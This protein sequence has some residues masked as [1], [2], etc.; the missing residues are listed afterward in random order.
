[1][2]NKNRK[3]IEAVLEADDL[4]FK[5]LKRVSDCLIDPSLEVN[6]VMAGYFLVALI[7][8]REFV[9]LDGE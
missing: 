1:M 3:N 6:S 5:E 8:Y 2:T 4:I 9:K 7:H